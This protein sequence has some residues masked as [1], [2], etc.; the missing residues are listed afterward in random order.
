MEEMIYRIRK[1]NEE[2]KVEKV[3]KCRWRDETPR[4]GTPRRR[5][6][7]RPN[8]KRPNAKATERQGDIMPSATLGQV[9]H[10]AKWN[11]KP[12][13]TLCQVKAN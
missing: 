7:K 3:H 6:A 8:A 13:E 2:M 5:N 11:I 12:S 9:R 4:D 10:Y 1:A